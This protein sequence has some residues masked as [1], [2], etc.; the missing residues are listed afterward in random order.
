MDSQG[1]EM[2]TPNINNIHLYVQK[3]KELKQTIRDL[4]GTFLF[5]F[6]Q[7]ASTYSFRKT[8]IKL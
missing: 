2:Y 4:V 1:A 5:H 7:S 6:L 8:N 3:K